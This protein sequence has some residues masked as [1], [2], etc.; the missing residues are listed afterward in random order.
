TQAIQDLLAGAGLNPNQYVTYFT[1]ALD[2]T[3]RGVDIVGDY[4]Q[5]LGAYGSIRYN[6]GFNWNTTE[7]DKIHASSVAQSALG[8]DGGYDRQRQGNL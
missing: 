6:A 4:R 7:I 8:P 5:E 1:N 3:T 2:T